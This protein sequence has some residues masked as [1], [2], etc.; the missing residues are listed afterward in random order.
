MKTLFVGLVSLILLNSCGSRL[1]YF[2]QKKESK[3]TYENITVTQP[4][5][6]RKHVIK[7]GDVLQIRLY[8]SDPT[9]IAMF[10]TNLLDEK[11]AI[12]GYQVKS[13]GTIFIPFVGNLYV[14]DQTLDVAQK[15]VRD[16]LSRYVNS[17]N[18]ALDLV[19][20]QVIVL[21]EVGLPGPTLVPTDK[22]SVI[23][24]IALTG[25]IS[26]YGNP[27]TIQL[28][29]EEGDIKRGHL[30]DISDVDVFR[31]PYYFVQSNDVLYVETL[32]RQFLR[33]N[34]SYLTMLSTLINTL[35]ILSLR[36]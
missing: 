19:A 14:K 2:Q 29:R 11:N 6:V 15:M 32:K 27:T 30:I 22:A 1:I 7:E 23:D 33:E 18:M 24:V 26:Q 21:G 16:S 28:I 5:D 35:V 20:F 3:N 36:F 34:L 10:N 17:P 4:P 25:D 13:N 9:L 12:S 31:N 8:S